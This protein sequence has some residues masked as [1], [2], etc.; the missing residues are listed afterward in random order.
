MKKINLLYPLFI[1]CFA[2]K[3]QIIAGD[4]INANVQYSNTPE[5]NF[6]DSPYVDLDNDGIMDVEFYIYQDM[7]ALGEYRTF[8]DAIAKHT[9]IQFVVRQSVSNA[10][11][12]ITNSSLIDNNLNWQNGTSARYF[13]ENDFTGAN[14][15]SGVFWDGVSGG[16]DNLMGFRIIHPT[17]TAYG[18]ILIGSNAVK[19][20]SFAIQKTVTGIKQL[21]NNNVQVEVYPNPA[22]NYIKVTATKNITEIKLIDVLGKEVINSEE[23]NIDINSFNDG[24][25]FV[26]VETGEGILTKK[27]IVQH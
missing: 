22:N 25:Y 7:P 4:S 16:K 13:V 20:K 26:R 10:Y 14:N 5:A 21:D 23:K 3:A 6:S 8:Y 11:D 17:D 27:I 18:W 24:V 15:Y 19:V 9:G 2:A 1:F 12:T